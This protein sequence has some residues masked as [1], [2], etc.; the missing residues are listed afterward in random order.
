MTARGI[1]AVTEVWYEL[2]Q[3][4]GM[5]V[6]LPGTAVGNVSLGWHD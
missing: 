1:I 5:G 4:I 3:T 2:V 6:G